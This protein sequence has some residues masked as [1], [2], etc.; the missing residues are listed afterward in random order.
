MQ[1]MANIALR[2]ARQASTH[3]SRAFDRPDLLKISEKAHNDFVTNVDR[4]VEYLIVE[5]LKTTF[6]DHNITGEESRNNQVHED[7]EYEWIIDPIDGTLNFLRQVPH[8]CVS[9]ACLHKGK[10]EH[11]VIVDP[12]R[13][14]EFVA[15]RGQGCQL[16]GHRVRVS[17]KEELDGAMIAT[18][19]PIPDPDAQSQLYAQM[20]R[21]KTKVRHTGSACL[22]LAYVA[23]G[24]MDAL[25]LHDLKPWDL[26]AGVLMISESGGLIGDFAGGADYMKSGNIVAGA[27]RCFK[28]LAPLV[29]TFLS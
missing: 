21:E 25:W 26:A 7:A 15:S 13:N 18:G 17:P 9:I 20:L 22:D 10:L 6:P 12:M 28:A 8:F 16:N 3:I 24:R 4:E 2:T 23:A 11:A 1:P 29:K 5:A 14:E 19:G 27:P